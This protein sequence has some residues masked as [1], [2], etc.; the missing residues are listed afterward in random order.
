M[1]PNNYNIIKVFKKISLT[2]LQP[3]KHLF[4]KNNRLKFQNYIY[5]KIE[6]YESPNRIKVW[7]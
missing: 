6:I 5:F 4:K 1:V 7:S 2:G 3:V